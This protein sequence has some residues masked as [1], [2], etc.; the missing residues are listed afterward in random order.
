MSVWSS[1]VGTDCRMP[2]LATLSG[3][4]LAGPE[5]VA[6]VVDSLFGLPFPAFYA[7]T[8]RH[9]RTWTW[10]W[11]ELGQSCVLCQPTL[12]MTTAMMTTASLLLRGAALLCGRG[13]I[14][15][16]GA[17]VWWGVRFVELHGDWVGVDEG[18][19]VDR[20]SGSCH[21]PGGED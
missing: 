10:N 16:G 5:V 9:S 11:A 6:V 21:Q 7:C 8:A 12:M 18:G 19:R 1:A 17:R 13:E 3:L 4:G 15:Y 20:E 2:A 14:L